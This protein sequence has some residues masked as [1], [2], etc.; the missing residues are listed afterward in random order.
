VGTCDTGKLVVGEVPWLHTE[1][2]A[3]RTAFHIGFADV[4]VELYWCEETLSVL[5]V[6]GQDF[7]TELHLSACFIDPLAHLE[8]HWS[9][10]V[11]YVG[12]QDAG[13][14]CHD[15]CPLREAR[16]PPFLKTDR[17]AFKCSCDLFVV[18]VIE[19][20]QK[21]AIVWVDALITHDVT[22]GM[23]EN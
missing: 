5:G 7:R 14:L 2:Y 18:N 8:S 16:V 22:P 13:S 23:K 21:F 11:I 4:G 3:K 12:M 10:E 20:S 9:S 15:S 19:R 1:D 17:S 6:I